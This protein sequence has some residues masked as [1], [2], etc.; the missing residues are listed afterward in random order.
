LRTI[1]LIS[2]TK[3]APERNY[4]VATDVLKLHQQPVRKMVTQSLLGTFNPLRMLIEKQHPPV[5]MKSSL[6]ALNDVRVSAV[7][8]TSNFFSPIAE[9]SVAQNAKIH[10]AVW[11]M[12]GHT[13]INFRHRTTAAGAR[14]GKV[15]L[16]L[17]E[18]QRN[19]PT[20]ISLH[21]KVILKKTN[22]K[23]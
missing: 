15:V 19:A 5:K 20:C 1:H 6:G 22:K 10:S 21:K 11:A 16:D 23:H 14:A 3:R 2:F 12:T 17:R 9:H 13:P 8:M 4:L 18:S 7:L